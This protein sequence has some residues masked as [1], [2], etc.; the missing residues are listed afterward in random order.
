MYLCLKI[1][2]KT[3]VMSSQATKRVVENSLSLQFGKAESYFWTACEIKSDLF[4]EF[5]DNTV[6][7]NA[8]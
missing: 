1:S 5:I 8:K 2:L 4:F 3:Y 6:C 7:Q